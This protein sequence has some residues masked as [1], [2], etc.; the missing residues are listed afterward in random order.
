MTGLGAAWYTAGVRA[1]AKVNVFAC[2]TL[3]TSVIQGAR[4]AHATTTIIAVAIEARKLDWARQFGATDTVNASQND[5]V[6]QIK[7]RTNGSGVDYAFECGFSAGLAAGAGVPRPRR[8]RDPDRS[9]GSR[10]PLLVD[11][12]RRGDLK[13]S[14]LITQRVTL[15]VCLAA[16]DEVESSPA[17]LKAGE[18]RRPCC[19]IGPVRNPKAVSTPAATT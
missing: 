1:G 8:C 17:L 11:L 2:G 18:D 6:E 16:R 4:L 5:P 3:G 15:L 7:A 13:L 19:C 14:G 9:T 12:Y 10:F